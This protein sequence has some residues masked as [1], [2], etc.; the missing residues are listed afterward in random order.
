MSDEFASDS[1]SS[2]AAPVSDAPGDVSAA[3]DAAPDS[4]AGDYHP[5]IRRGQQRDSA[6]A[7]APAPAQP[8]EPAAGQQPAGQAAAQRSWSEAHTQ[9]AQYLGVEPETVDRMARSGKL[10]QIADLMQTRQQAGQSASPQQA[11]QQ[12]AA[13]AAAF[14]WDQNGE[15][16]PQFLKYSEHV[17]GQY[18]ALRA[19]MDRRLSEHAQQYQSLMSP[20]Q[21]LLQRQQQAQ[22]AADWRAINARLDAAHLDPSV[23]GPPEAPRSAERQKVYETALF[24]LQQGKAASLDEAADK[25]VRMEFGDRISPQITRQKLDRAQQRAAQVVPEPGSRD[26][27]LPPGRDKAIQTAKRLMNARRQK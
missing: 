25:A 11:Q 10:Q 26:A 9:W 7:P 20:V 1:P 16:F 17:K 3:P 19:E 2:D 15:A 4:A 27:D 21:Q 12:A 22:A 23:F 18:A 8:A 13:D 6:A 14:E 24:L 5:V